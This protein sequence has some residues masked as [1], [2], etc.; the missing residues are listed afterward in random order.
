MA[1]AGPR[2]A[3]LRRPDLRR[4]GAGPQRDVP[5]PGRR[6]GPPVLRPRRGP[7]AGEE[8]A[9]PGVPSQQTAN[10]VVRHRGR[11][12]LLPVD[13]GRAVRQPGGAAARTSTGST[14]SGEHFDRSPDPRRRRRAGRPGSR[15]SATRSARS[16]SPTCRASTSGSQAVVALDKLT[17]RRRARLG[18]VRAEGPL[19]PSCPRS[20][21]S[22]ST[23]SRSRPTS[24]NGGSSIAPRPRREAPDPRRELATG[25][26]G[27]TAAGVDSML[28]VP[29]A[30]TH[31]EYTDIPLRAAGLPLRAGPDQPST[32]RPGSATTCSTTR[33]PTTRCW[34][35]PSTTS[36]RLDR[37]VAV[38]HA[39]P[40]RAPVVLLLLRVRH[41]DGGRASGRRRH[42]RRGLRLSARTGRAAGVRR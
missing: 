22:R 26:D 12:R 27:W 1:G 8:T 33:P 2:R 3:R 15:W 37:H 32:C 7:A 14:R 24:P 21:C 35:R 16:R 34:R 20:A 39:R 4:P 18:A 29:R 5:A 17:T 6:R 41:R 25:F 31:L 42:R 19:V 13:P 9:C 40:R 11:D 30:S 10:F 28:V 38:G 36:S 23:A